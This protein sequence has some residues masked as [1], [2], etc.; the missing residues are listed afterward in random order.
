M[1]S[2]YPTL[3][4][5]SG[6]TNGSSGLSE[7]VGPETASQTVSV[8]LNS[9]S[10]CSEFSGDD[11]SADFAAF[12]TDRATSWGDYHDSDRVG[13]VRPPISGHPANVIVFK[14]E[15]DPGAYYLILSRPCTET[16]RSY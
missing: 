13:H 15:V 10:I 6:R 2:T 12:L 3:A 14:T 8:S 4:I 16:L 11:S 9:I 5:Q 1:E 7:P